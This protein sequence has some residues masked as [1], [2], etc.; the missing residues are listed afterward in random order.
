MSG[1]RAASSPR[2][3]ASAW[4]VAI[5]RRKDS[6]VI[7]RV[8]CE[9]G[10][11]TATGRPSTV[12][13]ISSP[14]ATRSS[15]E[16]FGCEVPSTALYACDKGRFARHREPA[17]SCCPAGRDVHDVRQLFDGQ[18][19]IHVDD[20]RRPAPR[21]KPEAASNERPRLRW[22]DGSARD[23]S[24]P[25]PPMGRRAQRCRIVQQWITPRS[26]PETPT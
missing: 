3:S 21:A 7:H 11:S 5:V 12:M 16:R 6:R 2:R 25:N 8:R 15:N 24:R 26:K 22:F 13:A 19:H 14:A 9:T 23:R 18:P 4:C 1:A 17:F 10:A 20:G